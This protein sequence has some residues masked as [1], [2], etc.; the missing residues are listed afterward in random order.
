M[1]DTQDESQISGELPGL[2]FI[3]AFKKKKKKDKKQTAVPN[4][5]IQKKSSRAGSWY[6]T[7]IHNMAS[8]GSVHCSLSGNLHTVSY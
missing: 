3:Q 2:L 4:S 7:I 6:K 1:S 8:P 5:T